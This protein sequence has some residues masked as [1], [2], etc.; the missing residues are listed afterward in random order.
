MTSEWMKYEKQQFRLFRRRESSKPVERRFRL[1]LVHGILTGSASRRISTTPRAGWWFVMPKYALLPMLAALSVYVVQYGVP[2]H[3][4]PSYKPGQSFRDCRTI[5]P[6]M[7]VVPAGTFLMGSPAGD[8]HQ[9]RDGI[10]QP[11][12]RVM[13]RHLFA[14]GKF[15][16]T[17]DEYAYFARET[18]LR[19]TD[20][21]NVHEPPNWPKKTG[22]NWHTTPFPQTGRDPVVCVSWEEARAYAQW[23]SKKTGHTYRLLSESE[24]EYAARAGTTGEAFWGDDEKRDC[25]YGNGVDLTVAGKFPNAKW[26]SPAPRNPNPGHVIPCHD[27]HVFTAPVGSYKPNALGLYDTAGNVFEWVA[28]CWSPNYVGAP[29]DGSP[30]TDGDCS[31]RVNRGGS[32]TSNPTGLRSAYRW[33]DATGLRVVDLGFRVARE[34]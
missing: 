5:C 29:T 2:A 20:G 26:E 11:Q 12:H 21:C 4:S 31:V 13:I 28:D 10:E 27:G 7:V 18:H 1:Q 30:R 23:L 19:D 6:E 3:A 22:L 24:W 15:E 16:V 32:W 33:N 17:R 8:P 25:E 34:L 14:V 9:A